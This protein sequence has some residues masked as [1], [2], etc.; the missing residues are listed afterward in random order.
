[1]P[2]PSWRR[3]S[4]PEHGERDSYPLTGDDLVGRL[5]SVE[6]SDRLSA[7][8]AL[9]QAL[10]ESAGPH[11]AVVEA[12]C[13]FV[14]SRTRVTPP[15]EEAVDALEDSA[16]RPDAS[17]PCPR[18]VAEQATGRGVPAENV[19]AA[20]NVLGRHM[21][22]EGTVRV[23]L[24]HADLRGADLTGAR[25]GGALLSEALLQG[26]RLD[27]AWLP[28]AYLGK[29][30][31]QGATLR[32]AQLQGAYLSDA[33]MQG[34]TLSGAQLQGAWLSRA[35]LE[36]ADL[37]GAQLQG[38]DLYEARLRDANM[39]GA[40]LTG[41]HGLT[42]QQLLLARVDTATRLP[43][44]LATDPRVRERIEACATGRPSTGPTRGHLGSDGNPTRGKRASFWVV[45]RVLVVG[46]V[47]AVVS[48]LLLLGV[49][50]GGPPDRDLRPSSS[51][52]ERLLASRQQIIDRLGSAD[53]QARVAM[54]GALGRTMAESP[55]EQDAIV[56]ALA[57]F[58]RARTTANPAA[59]L[60][61]PPPEPAPDVQAALTVLARSAG[62]GSGPIVE[63]PTWTA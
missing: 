57:A 41:V 47:I 16:R 34:A 4:D 43:Q 6:L 25:L 38:A 5:A 62:D 31:L 27:R 26:A 33:Q 54:I 59:R 2:Q 44:A 48:G 46:G 32:A 1:M 18:A 20:L 13:A 12:L 22:Q 52:T 28:D 11:D 61:T 19:Q 60:T 63:A 53:M 23:N 51:G 8:R 9:E 3:S 17:G 37:S 21:R 7:I 10:S 50:F 55:R 58:V 42:V 14:R 30:R 39:K 56:D 49:A 45:Q 40:D 24:R 15:F 36:D 29:A 35:C